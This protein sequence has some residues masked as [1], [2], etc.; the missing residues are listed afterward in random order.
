MPN[1]FE[2]D[3]GM[4]DDA[5]SL[6]TKALSSLLLVSSEAKKQAAM[7][8]FPEVIHGQL[9]RELSVLALQPVECLNRVSEK[10]KVSCQKP[11]KVLRRRYSTT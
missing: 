1:S 6:V 2:P 3:K 11:Q 7:H 4:V 8:E 9:C 10:K 5:P